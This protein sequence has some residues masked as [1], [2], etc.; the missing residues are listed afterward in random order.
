MKPDFA[1]RLAGSVG[2]QGR[3]EVRYYGIWGTICDDDFADAD[4]RVRVA[5][6]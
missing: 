6:L 5:G 3:V 4:A 1:M 2:Y